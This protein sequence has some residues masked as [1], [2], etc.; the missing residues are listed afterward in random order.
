MDTSP[1][2][3][4]VI[5]IVS[6]SQADA[7]LKHLTREGFHFTLIDSTNAVMQEPILCLMIG[8]FH[9]RQSPLLDIIRKDCEPYQKFIPTQSLLP[10]ELA[11]LPV[12]EARLGGALVYML[13]VVRFEQL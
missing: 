12:V 1:P 5:L 11:N 2:D 3:R 6:G 4:L 10:G 8:F 13:K 9:T 7:L